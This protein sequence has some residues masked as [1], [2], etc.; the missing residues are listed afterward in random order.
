MD[1]ESQYENLIFC[2]V[3]WLSRGS[4][5]ACVYELRDEFAS[6]LKNKSINITGFE[7]AEW[8]PSLEFLVHFTSQLNKLNFKEKIN[9]SRSCGIIF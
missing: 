5:L 1:V 6:F 9:L 4:M 7:D 3:R 2:E 8:L